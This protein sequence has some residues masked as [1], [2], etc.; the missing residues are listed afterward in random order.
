M[1]SPQLTE[2]FSAPLRKV[3]PHAAENVS[4][5]GGKIVCQPFA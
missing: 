5:R 3:F 2:S 4:A 1:G